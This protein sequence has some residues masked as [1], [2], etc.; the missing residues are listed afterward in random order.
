MKL[1]R[2]QKTARNLVLCALLGALVYALLGFPPYTIRGMLDRVERQYLLSDL[3]PV[4][5]EK[6]SRRYSNDFFPWHTTYLLARTGDT[7]V[8][9][10][11]SRHLLGV[12]PERYRYLK[13]NREALCTAID[14]TLYVAGSFEEAV[15]ATAEVTLERTTQV[16]DPET[17]ECETTYGEQRTYAY[18]GEKV[19][20]QVFSFRYREEGDFR[21]DYTSLIS[22]ASQWYRFYRKGEG[23]YSILHADVPVKV[24]LYGGDGEVL[25]TLEQT[26]DNY[27]FDSTW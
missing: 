1:N 25:E 17:E 26:V 4:L 24:T 22:L 2:E 5:V 21:H 12:W 9:T 27:E 20:S 11:S 6:S 19:N 10:S 3:E 7:Y 15:S 14:G 23:G 8:C 13:M 18:Q 16:Y